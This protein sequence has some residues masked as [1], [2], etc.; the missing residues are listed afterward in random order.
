MVTAWKRGKNPEYIFDLIKKIPQIKIKMVG[1]WLDASYKKEFQEKMRKN[2]FLK[3][4]DIVGE[5]SEK[6][7]S[8][9]YSQAIV[10]LQT[11]DDRGFGMPALEAA[12]NGTTFIIPGGQ[13]VC[14][15]FKNKIDGFYTKEQDTKAIIH[16]LNKL[17]NN[18][19]QS[20]RMGKHAWET[21][22]NYTWQKHAEKLI[23][24]SKI[25]AK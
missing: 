23:R 3:N 17:I 1:K 14:N 22:K 12:S 9:Y 20:I 6:E 8:N 19:N 2:N 18:K 7:L 24:I 11:N 10:L 15:L 13:G 21:V 5:V 25:Y 4:V 16:Y